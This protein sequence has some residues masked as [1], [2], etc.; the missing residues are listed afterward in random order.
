MDKPTFVTTL[1]TIFSDLSGKS[2]AVKATEIADAIEA[3]I[4][5]YKV[6][7]GIPVSTTGTAV[8]QSGATT[9]QGNLV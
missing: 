8:A 2:H 6:Q 9:A 4:S 5:S 1:T 3:F 7:I